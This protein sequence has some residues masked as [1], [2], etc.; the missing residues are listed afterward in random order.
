MKENP[1]YLYIIMRN[2][3]ESLTGTSD[4]RIAGKCAAQASHA[5]NLAIY[6]A[7]KLNLP[8]FNVLITEWEGNL[9]FG[10]CI[11]LGANIKKIF[12]ILNQADAETIHCGLCHDPTYPLRDGDVTHLIP[13]DTCAYIFGR[14]DDIKHLV[15]DLKLLP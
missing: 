13:I 12:E 10:T 5:S 3:M 1:V 8:N 6:D 9:G 4:K 11:V 15:S 14:K 7:K 2:D